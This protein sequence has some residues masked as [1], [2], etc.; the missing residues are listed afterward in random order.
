MSSNY[1]TID[2][3][4][5]ASTMIVVIGSMINFILGAVR[6]IGKILVF[7]RPILRHEPCSFYF[8]SSTCFNLSVILII[9]PTRILSEGLYIDFAIYKL[10]ICK[11]QFYSYYVIRTISVW[12]IV[13]A[14]IDRYLHSS[15]IL[16]IRQL[17]SIK[18]AKFLIDNT[19]L[20]IFIL[21]IHMII[22]YEV[23]YVSDR[24]GDRAL[25]CRVQ[26]NCYRIF[27]EF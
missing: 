4:N 25:T 8:L 1:S 7:T 15:T 16:R 13:L 27:F 24:F 22:F 17:S 9:I 11:I 26:S 21:F 3:L 18:T 10:G 6:L 12:L 5:E 2:Q 23:V 19:I 20:F 14:C